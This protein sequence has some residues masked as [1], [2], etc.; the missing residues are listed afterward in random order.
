MSASLR[1]KPHESDHPLTP[2]AV[3]LECHSCRRSGHCNLASW[4]CAFCCGD[5]SNFWWIQCPQTPT[6]NDPLQWHWIHWAALKPAGSSLQ[7]SQCISNTGG[8]YALQQRWLSHQYQTPD[9]HLPAKEFHSRA[10][11]L[12]WSSWV[13]FPSTHSLCSVR[14]PQIPCRHRP[15][16]MIRRSLRGA[17]FSVG[18][19]TLR[20]GETSPVRPL[21]FRRSYFLPRARKR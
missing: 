10:G 19:P 16:K 7:S 3:S 21:T 1:N 5:N 9:M 12:S 8:S 14:V 11:F 17:F 15:V 13:P 6:P 18:W 4:R 20:A 2:H